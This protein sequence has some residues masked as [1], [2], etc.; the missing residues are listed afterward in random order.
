MRA[1]HLPVFEAQ[2]DARTPS[3]G[4]PQLVEGQLGTPG[5]TAQNDERG[6]ER[7]QELSERHSRSGS[8]HLPISGRGESFLKRVTLARTPGSAFQSG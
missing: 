7:G 8:V 4:D 1:C 6:P 3:Q 5:G 2:V